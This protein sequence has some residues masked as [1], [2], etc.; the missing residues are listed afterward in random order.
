MVGLFHQP[1]SNPALTTIHPP[2]ILTSHADG[3]LLK[4]SIRKSLGERVET[5]E[6]AVSDA[7]FAADGAALAALKQ[8]ES[9]QNIHKHTPH[10]ETE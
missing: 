5:K 10:Y 3:D 4:R 2:K 9:W 1:I 6:G 7:L 8:L